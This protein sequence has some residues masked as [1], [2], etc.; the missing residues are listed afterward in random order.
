MTTDEHQMTPEEVAVYNAAIME[1]LQA[2]IIQVADHAKMAARIGRIQPLG[3]EGKLPREVVFDTQTVSGGFEKGFKPLIRQ[4]SLVRPFRTKYT[5]SRQDF[6]K[7][8]GDTLTAVPRNLVRPTML[9]MRDIFAR[10]LRCGDILPRGYAGSAFFAVDKFGTTGNFHHN[11]FLT[12]DAVDAG[13]DEMAT[14]GVEADT[15]IVPPA[16]YGA[17]VQAVEMRNHVVSRGGSAEVK[18][19]KPSRIK[20]I[21]LLPELDNGAIAATRTW[22]LLSCFGPHGPRA[23]YGAV[24]EGFEFLTTLG[25]PNPTNDL[26]WVAERHAAFEYGDATYINRYDQGEPSAPHPSDIDWLDKITTYP[27]PMFEDASVFD[28][29]DSGNTAIS[30]TGSLT[31]LIA[32][33]A[34]LTGLDADKIAAHVEQGLVV[35]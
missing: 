3:D 35:D 10:L 16:L 12:R 1:G 11:T 19:S 7:N 14:R 9:L 15:L 13:I 2:H 31:E 18:R 32:K 23:L 17:A 26:V 24:E 5:I 20:Q 29:Q 25:Q 21:I 28:Q 6:Y 4:R 33:V 8:L 27:G 34:A 22:Y 30:H